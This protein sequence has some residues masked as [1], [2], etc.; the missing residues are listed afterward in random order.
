MKYY[1]FT[2]SI[3]HNEPKFL[4][5]RSEDAVW[6]GSVLFAILDALQVLYDKMALLKF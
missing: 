5:R 4:D 1:H 2:W 3:Y 6:S